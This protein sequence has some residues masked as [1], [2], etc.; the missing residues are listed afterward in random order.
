MQQKKNNTACNC[1]CGLTLCL[2]LRHFFTFP[3]LTPPPLS[4]SIVLTN[5]PHLIELLTA[6]LLVSHLLYFY[7][8]CFFFVCLFYLHCLPMNGVAAGHMLSIAD[9]R[10]GI[11]LIHYHFEAFHGSHLAFCSLSMPFFHYRIIDMPLES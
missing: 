1:C 8:M 2:T 5:C 10:M 3:Y 11:W 9:T 6:F 4:L 7:F